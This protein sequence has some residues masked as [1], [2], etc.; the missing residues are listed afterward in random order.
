MTQQNLPERLS[1]CDQGTWEGDVF[2]ETGLCEAQDDNGKP[3]YTGPRERDVE[4]WLLD[5]GYLDTG[6]GI[7]Y[8]KKE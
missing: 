4:R 8:Q 5:N 7:H 6:D 3:Y 1:I 2:V